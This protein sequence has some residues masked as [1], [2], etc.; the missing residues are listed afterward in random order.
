MHEIPEARAIH[1]DD[2]DEFE[3]ADLMIK[4]DLLKFPWMG[5]L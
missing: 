5:A 1:I 3:R 4:H 2:L